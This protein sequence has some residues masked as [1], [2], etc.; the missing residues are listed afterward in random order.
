MVEVILNFEGN[1][2]IIQCNTTDKMS[3][4]IKKF[5]IKINNQ[6]NSNN[7]IYLYNGAGINNE[8]TFDEQANETDKKRKKMNVIV[9]M[10]GDFNNEKKEIMSKDII[11]PK[12]KQNIFLDM[13][14][15]K[16]NLY[17]CK[18]KHNINDILL[19]K[20]T[21]TQKIDLNQIICELC[22]NNNK[23]STHQNQFFICNTCNKNICPLCKSVHNKNHYIIDYDDKNYLCKKHNEPFIKYCKACN[24]D[25]CARCEKEHKSH[26]VI[27]LSNLFINEGEFTKIKDELKGVI[28][29]FKY[30]INVI[31]VIFDRMIDLLDEYF[32]INT[33]IINNYNISKR[34]YYKLQNLKYLKINNEIL[35]KDLNNIIEN[36]KIS[37]LYDYIINNFYNEN[38]E[39][40]IGETKNKLKDGKGVLYYDKNNES[41]RKKYEG[42]FKQNNLEGKGI[43]YWNDGSR[44]NGDWK[45][46]KREGKGIYLYSSGNRYEGDFKNGQ[47]EGKGIFYYSSGDRYEGEFKN[48]IIEGNGIFYYSNGDRYE[49]EFKNGI[50]EGRGTMHYTK[51]K[52]KQ[53]IWKNDKYKGK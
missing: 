45:N 49:G 13:K 26:D 30:K 36:D 33:N 11:C 12:C 50:R 3:D 27:E 31:K 51:G 23:G 2:S 20:Y 44:Y 34:N 15:F 14:N 5:L 7:F 52:P 28:D 21:E 19:N 16:I 17:G 40:Y 47:S 22:K 8:L 32:I 42:Y 1:N 4:V 39:K 18:N 46:G 10:S 38:G 35:I 41:D 43:L 24:E 48:G 6:D 29:K 37:E 53:G 9:T 25:M